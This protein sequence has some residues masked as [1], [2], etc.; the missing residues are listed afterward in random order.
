[1]DILEKAFD[2]NKQEKSY[3][4]CTKELSPVGRKVLYDNLGKNILSKTEENTTNMGWNFY[5]KIK[6]PFL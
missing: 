1:M 3:N 5:Y 4:L 2:K 6:Y